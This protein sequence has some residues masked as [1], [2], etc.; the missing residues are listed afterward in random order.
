MYI[1]SIGFKSRAIY[2]LESVSEHQLSAKEASE[3][4]TYLYVN[5]GVRWVSV[6]RSSF[7]LLN[8]P[9]GLLSNSYVNSVYFASGAAANHFCL[10]F[11]SYFT[12]SST[13]SKPSQM[14]TYSILVS[15][16]C[17]YLLMCFQEDLRFLG[18]HQSGIWWRT[19]AQNVWDTVQCHMN[20]TS[21]G[22][23]A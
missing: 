12:L 10:C 20:S 2:L 9:M 21:D 17:L 4:Q 23:A 13:L 22:W 16:V 15:L 19:K 3:L 6:P 14:V 18:K 7:P 11:F 1:V 5:T 8:F